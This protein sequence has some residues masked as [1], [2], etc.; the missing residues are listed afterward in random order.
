MDRD[1]RAELRQFFINRRSLHRSER[2]THLVSLLSPSL[3]QRAVLSQCQWLLRVPYLRE[4]NVLFIGKLQALL[5]GQVYPPHE[6]IQWEDAL[7]QVSCG[8][9][10]RGGHIMTT[11]TFWGIDTILWNPALKNREPCNTLTYVE[12]LTLRR[13]D[14]FETLLLF[15]RAAQYSPGVFD[16]ALHHTWSCDDRQTENEGKCSTMGGGV[17]GWW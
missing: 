9:V 15:S 6:I 5:K 13:R 1:F 16:Q 4:A 3:K 11:G 8:I 7:C 12:V 14:F 10:S 17:W 2:E